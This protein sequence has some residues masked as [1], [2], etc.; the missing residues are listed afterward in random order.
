MEGCYSAWAK[1]RYSFPAA[2]VYI[3]ALV[4]AGKW[5]RLLYVLEY[6]D[7][8]DN[9]FGISYL[10]KYFSTY[11]FPFNIG[12]AC[13]AQG[14][15]GF[16][17]AALE[18]ALQEIEKSGDKSRLIERL[19]VFG[20]FYYD[21]YDRVDETIRLWEEA[22]WRMNTAESSTK[23]MF[24]EAKLLYTN[25]IAQIYFDIAVQNCDGTH[26]A[27]FPLRNTG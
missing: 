25:Q 2:T 14:K 26:N 20:S 16:I 5:K 1:D 7:D 4:V 19:L 10:V 6:L 13:R 24:S 27:N 15:P 18:N 22:L 3:Q 9:G 17:I 23:I 12:R 8:S 11:D 21:F